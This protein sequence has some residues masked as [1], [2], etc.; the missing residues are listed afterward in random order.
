[1]TAKRGV[2]T[3]SLL[4]MAVLLAT[5]SAAA[6]QFDRRA[7]QAQPLAANPSLTAY[8]GGV[9]TPENRIALRLLEYR[10]E[11]RPRGALADYELELRFAGAA[12][13][14]RLEGHLEVALPTGAVVNG[15]ALDVG[16]TLIEASLVEQ[17]KAAAAYEARVRE[18]VDPA[19]GEVDRATGGFTTRVFP[20][21]PEG[22]RIRLRFVAPIGA[23]SRLP[24][25]LGVDTGAWSVRVW[26]DAEG[27]ASA[28]LGGRALGTEVR[29]DRGDL[30]SEL[31]LR[32]GPATR[33]L[34]AQHP[35]TRERSWQIGGRLPDASAA[36]VRSV[37]ILW[38]RSR[39]M[40][41]VDA[42][43]LI[44]RVEEAVA[45]FGVR[46]VELTSFDSTA[47]ES[48][49][50]AAGDLRAA[51]QRERYA[52]ATGF[53]QL[54]ALSP[55]DV[56][57]LVSDG[58]PTL[59]EALGP[60]P[61]RSFAIAAGGGADRA[62]LAEDV[63]AE[64]AQARHAVGG[65]QL[66]AVLEVLPLLG[67]QDG[68]GQGTGV[69]RPERHRTE[70]HQQAVHAAHR[71]AAGLK[72]NVRGAARHHG[73]Q[74]FIQGH[75]GPPA[76]RGMLSMRRTPNSRAAIRMRLKGSSVTVACS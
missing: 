6:A 60:L 44:A 2:L 10:L 49:T 21:G 37:R 36:P 17:A 16:G 7:T 42:A 35:L 41:D 71:G 25:V 59:G 52:G 69:C 34:A 66:L 29:S 47:R 18:R 32:P 23:E 67:R 40:L 43:P 39:S 22:R 30:A 12:G 58:R 15:Y 3:S 54:A 11:V 57:I 38:D 74:Q 75:A 46:E 68:L 61:C 72:V 33:P 27:G 9:R 56:C 5:P 45:A 76:L 8:R 53:G 50:I 73:T 26:P 13:E 64:P 20:I 70:R 28:T 4:A 63:A 19:L 14:Q 31:V 65:V 51:L 24:I 62:A 48:R 55:S 1:M